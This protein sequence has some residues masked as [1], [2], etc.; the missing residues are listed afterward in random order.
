MRTLVATPHAAP[1]APAAGGHAETEPKPQWPDRPPD[2]VSAADFPGSF[3]IPGSDAAVRIG[4]MVRVNWVTTFDPLLVSDRFITSKIPVDVADAPVGGRVDVIAIPSRFNLD[5]RTPTGVGYMRAFLEADFSGSG[6]TLSLRHAYGQWRRFLFGQTWST[7]SDPD[8]VPD[9]IDFEGLN[10][11]VHFRQPQIRWTWAATDRVRVVMA[12]ENADTEITGATAANQ[13]PDF[14]SR[15]RW[16][17][18]RGGH[19]Q[20]AGLFRQLRGFPSNVP[21]DLVGAQGWGVNASGSLP[22]PFMSE[23]D[24]VLFQV[25]R[26][27]GIGHYI[28]DL[29]AEGGQDGVFDPTTSTIRVL[30]AFSGYASYDHWW[31][32]QIHSALTAGLVNVTTLDIQPGSALYRTDRYSGNVIWSPIPRL[33][34]VMELLYGIR[35]NRDLHRES[36]LQLQ[37]GS[38]FR[39]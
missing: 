37:I 27:A 5:F 20:V 15:I 8:A 29:N 24:L 25:N 7:F 6:N 32:G 21:A 16:G 33:E 22:S 2:V 30:P 35:V 31:S 3:R 18:E 38:T 12:L 23:R 19:I 4:G 17:P 14:V 34:L 26:G 9:G 13:R 36:A 1:A 10:A 39:F 28:K 11:T